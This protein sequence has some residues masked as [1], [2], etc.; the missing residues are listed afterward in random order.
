MLCTHCSPPF[1]S[2]SLSLCDF[3]TAVWSKSSIGKGKVDCHEPKYTEPTRDDTHG[4]NCTR[5][6]NVIYGFHSVV[7]G[8]MS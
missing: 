6:R 3:T 4:F 8:R 2:L 5:G 1:R 7:G